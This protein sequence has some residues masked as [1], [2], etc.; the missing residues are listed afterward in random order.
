MKFVN[1]EQKL[2]QTVVIIVEHMHISAR[3]H[4]SCNMLAPFRYVL[5]Y[6]WNGIA[7]IYASHVYTTVTAHSPTQCKY[8]E[9]T[10]TLIHF[11]ITLFAI[12]MPRRSSTYKF[13]IIIISTLITHTVS[14][15]TNQ[16]RQ[17]LFMSP[18][19]WSCPWVLYSEL[20]CTALNVN[21]GLMWVSLTPIAFS[22]VCHRPLYPHMHRV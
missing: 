5:L 4:T 19:R 16:K 20:H 1:R 2:L 9:W 11:G 22:F 6:L 18:V 12:C 17:F 8:N 13:N 10:S 3:V 7:S 15:V 14:R 21:D